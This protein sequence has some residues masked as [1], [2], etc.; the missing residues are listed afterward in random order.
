MQQGAFTCTIGTQQRNKSALLNFKV[1]LIEHTPAIVPLAHVQCLHDLA[2]LYGLVLLKR[3]S[4]SGHWLTSLLLKRLD[5]H[6][7]HPGD[8]HA[9]DSYACGDLGAVC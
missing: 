2:G 8:Q 6:H 3:D 1:N 4:G 5:E 9:K 7:H